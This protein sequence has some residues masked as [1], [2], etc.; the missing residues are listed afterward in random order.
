MWRGPE[1]LSTRTQALLT[2]CVVLGIIALGVNLGPGSLETGA[3]TPVGEGVSDRHL[4]GR[5]AG[6]LL[7]GSDNLTSQVAELESLL[8]RRFEVLEGQVETLRTAPPPPPKK[9]G[10]SPAPG[11]A[12]APVSESVR[13]GPPILN[14]PRC[15]GS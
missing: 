6:S 3:T 12:Q 4:S 15:R 1:T 2:A 11:E 7:G 10:Q 5:R 13:F 9:E 14:R 8:T